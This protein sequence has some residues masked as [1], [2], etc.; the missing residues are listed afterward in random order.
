MVS[1]VGHFV[2][3][4]KNTAVCNCIRFVWT[5]VIST[6]NSAPHIS[7]CRIPRLYDAADY[8]PDS[9]WVDT[10]DVYDSTCRFYYSALYT[11]Q[12]N[13]TTLRSRCVSTKLVL[14]HLHCAPI[15]QDFKL[16]QIARGPVNLGFT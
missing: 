2:A 7:N 6:R 5:T 15:A 4:G 11:E 12:N 10:A 16:M 9:I 14:L 1:F 13:K 8:A 3:E